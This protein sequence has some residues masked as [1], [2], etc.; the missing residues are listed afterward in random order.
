[1]AAGFEKEPSVIYNEDTGQGGSWPKA[2]G[3]PVRLLPLS[4]TLSL[5]SLALHPPLSSLFA[6]AAVAHF[7]GDGVSFGNDGPGLFWS[8]RRARSS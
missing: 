8:D 7:L 1:M 3:T 6:N 5:F 2:E 4:A